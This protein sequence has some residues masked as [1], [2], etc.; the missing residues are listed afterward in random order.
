MSKKTVE[1]TVEQM[2][3]GVIAGNMSVVADM[4]L[5]VLLQVL[6]GVA[7][8]ARENGK[9]GGKRKGEVLA[10][11]REGN[12]LISEIAE[13]LNITDRNVSSILSALKKDGFVIWNDEKG[14]KMLREETN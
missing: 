2:V 6:E 10:V 8:K 14:R 7:E 3:E 13:K 5:E 4:D 11:L 1:M 12:F 9:G